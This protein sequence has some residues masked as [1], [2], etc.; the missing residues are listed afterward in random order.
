MKGKYSG[1][2]MTIYEYVLPGAVSLANWAWRTDN[3]SEKAKQKLKVIDWLR[4]HKGNASLTARHFGLTRKTVKKWRNNFNKFGISGLNDKS[5]RPKKLRTMITSWL[6]INEI[7]KLRRKYPVWSKYKISKILE[8]DKNITVSASTV[9]RVLKK[10]D[11]IN[12]KKS[13]KRRKAAK[14]PRKRFPKGFRIHCEGDMVQMDTKH[15]SL[16]GGKKI[17]Q[18]TVIDVLTKRRIL[19]YYPSLASKNGADFL[20]HCIARFPFVI[21][22]VQTDN[23]PEFLGDFEKLCAELNLSH[24]F[25][26]TK[27]PKQNTYVENSHGFDEIEFYQQGNGY[28][29]TIEVAQK[30]LD[31]WEHTWNF[32]RPHEALNYLTPDEY[33]RKYKVEILPTKNVIILQA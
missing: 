9:G 5:H 32:I 30:K 23:G 29:A 18:F 15:A 24:Y 20:K 13:K 21:K 1:R 2:H 12:K 25:I 17:Y 8:R 3:I 10:K 33:S 28:Y 4:A 27:T 31:E 22:N 11:L 19:K 7:V 26:E 16:V 6:I 14:N